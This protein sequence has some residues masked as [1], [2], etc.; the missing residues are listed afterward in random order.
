MN[1]LLRYSVG[2]VVQ[3]TCALFCVYGSKLTLSISNKC[4]KFNLT[5]LI[6]T[7]VDLGF[8]QGPNFFLKL[9]LASKCISIFKTCIFGVEK[10]GA[11]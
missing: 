1:L 8:N 6:L 4:Q 11:K 3:N 9:Y 5:N 10:C 7:L 2:S